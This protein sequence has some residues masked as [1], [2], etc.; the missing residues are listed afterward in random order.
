MVRPASSDKW[1]VPW[2][3]IPDI[4]IVDVE[5]EKTNSHQNTKDGKAEDKPE[6]HWMDTF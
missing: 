5:Y 1:K 6:Q 2:D 3:S 4:S